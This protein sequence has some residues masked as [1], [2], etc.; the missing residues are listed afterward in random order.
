MPNSRSAEKR[1][2][3][4]EKARVRNSAVKSKVR[5]LEKKFHAAITTGDKS[6][7]ETALKSALS[8]YDKAAK[9]G[10]VHKNKVSR[11][12]HQFDV[13]MKSLAG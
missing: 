12:K 4:N 5:T 9:A 10:L 11:K 3:Q 13:A 2:R 6:V 1:V 8:A 7:A